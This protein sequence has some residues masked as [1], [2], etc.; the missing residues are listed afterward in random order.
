MSEKQTQAEIDH[1]L[2]RAEVMSF[3][4]EMPHEGPALYSHELVYEEAVAKNL[5]E[6]TANRLAGASIDE[7]M[8]DIQDFLG[9][10]KAKRITR[11]K[12]LAGLSAVVASGA[13]MMSNG[14]PG[15]VY[16]NIKTFPA[17]VS[18]I[19]NGYVDNSH[20]NGAHH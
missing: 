4:S 3:R 18:Y 8:K 11:G 7:L 5:T 17:H 1:R 19:F 6:V 10:N 14:G 2:S 13:L 15:Q 9:P 16:E 12:V 20:S